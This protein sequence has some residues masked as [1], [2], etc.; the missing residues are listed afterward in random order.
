MIASIFTYQNKTSKAMPEMKVKQKKKPIPK[1]LSK[2][3]KY[4]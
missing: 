3:L 4:Y 1:M 2:Q